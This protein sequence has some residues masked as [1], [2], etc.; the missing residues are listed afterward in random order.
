MGDGEDLSSGGEFGTHG[1]RCGAE[2]L[3]PELRGEDGRREAQDR[4]PSTGRVLPEEDRRA[5]EETA[6]DGGRTL[7]RFDRRPQGEY[8]EAGRDRGQESRGQHTLSIEAPEENAQAQDGQSVKE[9]EARVRV[10]K[11]ARDGAPSLAM[12]EYGAAIE[13]ESIEARCCEA[14]DQG[15]DC[16]TEEERAAPP[17]G[18]YG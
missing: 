5:P 14:G 2:E 12:L 4:S 6:R 10:E 16:A 13:A 7:H 11:L 15:G 17:A 1:R 8:A 18:L 3:K 9:E